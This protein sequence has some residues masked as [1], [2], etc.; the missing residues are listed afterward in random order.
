MGDRGGWEPLC[1]GNTEKGQWR[2]NV[3]H[4]KKQNPRVFTEQMQMEAMLE[5]A[6]ERSYARKLR[7]A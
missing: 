2:L 5:G 3:S 4:R 7:I 1:S 6:N